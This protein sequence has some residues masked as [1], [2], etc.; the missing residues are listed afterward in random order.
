[1]KKQALHI[2]LVEDNLVDARQIIRQLSRL[3]RV[4]A[5]IVHVETY[6][7]AIDALVES[8][9]GFDI[10]LLDLGLP[11][12]SEFEALRGLSAQ[13]PWV[14]VIVLSGF[15]EDAIL[16]LTMDMGAQDYLQKGSYEP[17]LLG[18]AISHAIKR[19]ASLEILH[20]LEAR[21]QV[22]ERF[23]EELVIVHELSG[24]CLYTSGALQIFSGKYR[25]NLVGKA[26]QNL[27]YPRDRDE[28]NRRVRELG[29]LDV[30]TFRFRLEGKQGK[31]EWVESRT[32]WL[33]DGEDRDAPPLISVWRDVTEQQKLQEQLLHSQKMEAVGRLTGGVAHDFNNLLTIVLSCSES[34]L[35]SLPD[36][37]R[38][39]E[40]VRMIMDAAERGAALTRQ[41]LTFS[42]QELIQIMSADLNEVVNSLSGMLERTIGEHIELEVQLAARPC[43]IQSDI[44][45]LEQVVMNLV[46]NA[47]EAMPAGGKVRVETGA[48]S[49]DKD[50]LP[51]AA[52]APGYY[53]FVRVKDQGLGM[54]AD[55]RSKI[56]EPFF[57][58]KERVGGMGLGLANVYAIASQ[59]RGF[60]TVDSE[61][62][63]G[64]TFTVYFP[65][66]ENAD[67]LDRQDEGKKKSELREA[68]ILYAEDDD[69]LRRLASNLL[70]EQ[71]FSVSSAS[72]GIE[73]LEL[74]RAARNPFDLVITDVVMPKMG[75]AMLARYVQE[76]S[77]G[78]IIL[79]T[80]GYTEDA[81]FVEEF[82]SK[83][84]PC[85]IKP[86]APS[87]LLAKI[88]ECLELREQQALDEQE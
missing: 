82:S 55:V 84:F 52:P 31:T 74:L 59:R 19:K 70:T 34:L 11:D 77:P 5:E 66:H 37:H 75:G 28:F 22:V 15:D 8:Q 87:K 38:G 78:T 85:L 51:A 60:I 64:S 26:I 45:Q 13:F 56:F 49:F 54:S 62:G 39:V 48:V 14:P 40:D 23:T 53:Y 17:A 33:D 12:T 71:G 41:L 61:V 1:M 42:R 43:F 67:E 57:S 24:E 35:G 27:M 9:A 69:M 20:Q 79:F 76:E 2:L 68:N 81:T 3:E 7:G 32:T 47:R 88:Q 50:S 83:R 44:S 10:I 58:T 86:F 63:V 25:T 4:H 16:D 72:N 21:Q 80:T 65:R 36:N 29:P 6:E 30:M 46:I 18:R 73:A